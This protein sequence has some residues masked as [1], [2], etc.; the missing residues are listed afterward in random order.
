MKITVV[1]SSRRTIGVEVN[2]GQVLIRSPRFATQAQIRTVV[3]KNRDWIEAQ[4]QKQAELSE[5]MRQLPPL[6]EA[7]RK[8]L[9]VEARAYIP[10]RVAYYA[11][12]LSVSY[13]RI[14]LRCQKTKWGSCSSQGNLNFNW[15]LMLAPAEVIDSVVVHELCHRKVMNHSGD[16]YELLH[17]VFPRYDECAR[18][19]REHGAELQYRAGQ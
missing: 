19:L 5:K 12:L 14:T 17:R 18:W 10:G 6:S 11:D 13:G 15:L 8:A 16:F 2:K 4:I 9:I 1:R 3:E 7:E